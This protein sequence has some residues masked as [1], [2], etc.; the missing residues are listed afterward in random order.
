MAT[1]SVLNFE[2]K[3]YIS[4]LSL[5]FAKSWKNGVFRASIS[6]KKGIS[7]NWLIGFQPASA[8][9]HWFRFK[10]MFIFVVFSVYSFVINYISWH[11][12]IWEYSRHKVI[13]ILVCFVFNCKSR[14]KGVSE[15]LVIEN[16]ERVGIF[17]ALILSP[18]DKKKG[19]RGKNHWKGVCFE[20]WRTDMV[21]TFYVELAYQGRTFLYLHHTQQVHLLT[22]WA[23]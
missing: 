20:K 13:L 5:R 7:Q 4:L 14:W 19:G 23:L 15:Y 16:L 3:R 17:F 11:R 9:V 21:T 18:I 1:M 12:T 2:E 10:G 8:A 22:P 6:A